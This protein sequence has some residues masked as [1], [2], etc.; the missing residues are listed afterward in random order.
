MKGDFSR[1]TFRSTN[2]YSSVRSQQGRVQVDADWNEAIDILAHWD[3]TT[4][5]D[6][7]GLCGGPQGQ[8]SDGNG[9]AGFLIEVG[10]GDMSWITR[11][12]YYVDGILVENE[13]E[14][15][16]TEQPHL[17]GYPLPSAA[18][19]YLVY[20]DVWE[21]H[22]TALEDP[23]IR[24][25]ALG[26]PDT[27]TRTKV[28]WQV[29]LLRV[30]DQD[31]GSLNCAS[32]VAAW[33]GATTPS[34]GRLSARAEPG[35]EEKDD[36][37]VVPAQAGYRGLENQLYRVEVHRVISAEKITIKWSRENGSVVFRW[38][39]QDDLNPNKLT[40]SSTGRDDVLGLATDDWVELTDDTHE[41][42]GEA[43][44]LVKV[45]SVE[46]K[47]LTIDPGSDTV[48]IDE[49]PVNPKVRR[50]DMPRDVGEI[51]VD[52]NGTD[53]WIALETGVEVKLEPGTYRTGDYWLIPARTAKRDIEWPRDDAGN[54]LPQLPH[55]IQHHY[56]RL[57]L[58]RFDGGT[59]ERLNDCRNLFPPLTE[60][61]R[62]FHVSGD[63]QAA[64]PGKELPQPLQVGVVNGQRPVEGARVQ[65]EVVLGEGSLDGG[66]GG[67]VLVETGPDGVAGCHWKLDEE[68][69]SQQVE[70]T[71]LEI[72][73]KPMV[74]ED[75]TP[76]LTPI[77]FNANLSIASQVYYNPESCI[78][79]QKPA[80]VQEALDQL[81]ENYALYYVSGDGQEAMPGEK[82]PHP[83]VV[84]VANGRWPASDETVIFEI[85]EGEGVLEA[86]NQSSNRVE[87]KSDENGLAWCTWQL[88][89]LD[90]GGKPPPYRVKAYLKEYAGDEG[91][92]VWFNANLSVASL[93]Y[94]DS[95]A[96]LELDGAQVDTVQEAIDALCKQGPGE[97]RGIH[98]QDVLLKTDTPKPLDHDREVQVTDLVQGLRVECD[99]EIAPGCVGG[100]PTCLLTLDMPFPF[101]CADM[102]VWG[103]DVIG[104][105][106]LILDAIV[107]A[108]RQAIL[109]N[110]TE[111]TCTWLT[112]VLFE[113]MKELNRGN[114][115]LAHLT[116]KG[117]FIW[118]GEPELYLDGE[119]FGTHQRLDFPSGDG[120]RGGDFE[121]WFWLVE[122][123]EAMVGGIGIIPSLGSPIFSQ[124]KAREAIN[125]AIDRD[126]LKDVLPDDYQVDT[127]QPYKPGEAGNIIA[128][129]SRKEL[130]A[131]V[132]ERLAR[133][134]YM[135]QGMLEDVGLD[136]KYHRVSD[137]KVVPTVQKALDLALPLDMV[138]GDEELAKTLTG[139]FPRIFDGT[140]LRF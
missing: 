50:W 77:R 34:S 11:G 113:K 18:G 38:T 55:G 129:W 14:V 49:F 87:V 127:S 94:Y 116:L 51:S 57:A 98:V 91:L 48:D 135:I 69:P 27:T 71:L 104:F 8:D 102:E 122:G 81:C 42:C 114:R 108:N 10:D 46:G 58:L 106:P 16:I 100:K 93:V 9:L 6:V 35:A 64:M 119:A 95:S 37:C 74:D 134:A 96:C 80:T 97:E 33:N 23:S 36:P 30:G 83:L 53:D 41:L 3:R 13:D 24:E 139:S 125:L 99:H 92:P 115:I 128:K 43:G 45:V 40:L 84:R 85:V 138:I 20:L 63:G 4:R 82:L 31:D 78:N 28:V 21:R 29:K 59:W 136:F 140:L 107:F 22:I 15:A 76:L 124:P 1:N 54:P 70:A 111:P 117:N 7:I 39:D 130:N 79:P 72:D 65:F 52:L 47:V 73:G 75:G 121:M 61:I 5:G 60:M 89:E 32:V 103:V 17:P 90:P 101:N 88:D 26:G 120:R 110:P 131:I 2:H 68:P 118:A 25:V 44:L 133:A 105:R 62:F 112:K 66:G 56:C 86:G 132:G 137:S 123:Q 126:R 67:E 12:R 109:W 19:I